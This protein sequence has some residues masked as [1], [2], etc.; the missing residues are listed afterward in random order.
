MTAGNA[1]IAQARATKRRPNRRLLENV[2][3]YITDLFKVGG[4]DDEHCSLFFGGS[5]SV[6]LLLLLLLVGGLCVLLYLY[7]HVSNVQALFS[8]VAMH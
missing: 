6:L 2:A 5:G 4:K 1:Y 3:I 8:C 7:I